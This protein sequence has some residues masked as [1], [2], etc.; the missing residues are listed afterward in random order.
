MA[1]WAPGRRLCVA[2]REVKHCSRARNGQPNVLCRRCYDDDAEWTAC[3]ACGVVARV[4]DERCACCSFADDARR[5]VIAFHHPLEGKR[6]ACRLLADAHL[7]GGLAPRFRAFVM[8]MRPRC[9]LHV[10]RVLAWRCHGD[11]LGLLAAPGEG[12]FRDLAHPRAYVPALAKHLT[13]LYRDGRWPTGDAPIVLCGVGSVPPVAALPAHEWARLRAFEGSLTRDHGQLEG[14]FWQTI[15]GNPAA[16]PAGVPIRAALR[17]MRDGLQ[18]P[19]EQLKPSPGYGLAR[20]L[21]LERAFRE[22]LC[23]P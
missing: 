6:N 22:S 14:G 5:G 3:G 15:T 13:K 4:V 17:R 18:F 21:S 10:A 2:C 8:P 20:Y 11:L 7:R 9:T 19:A 1:G 16:V 12:T 23:A